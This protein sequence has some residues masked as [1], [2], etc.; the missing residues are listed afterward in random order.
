M[1]FIP[2]GLLLVTVHLSL[3]SGDEKPA[4]L[5]G[6]IP[7]KM[8]EFVDQHDIA[9]AVTV[10]GRKDSIL[11]F[12]AVGSL[13][14][15]KKQPM[16]KDALFRIA[17]MTKPITAIGIMMLVDEGKLSVDD[18]VEKHLP[19]FRGQMLIANRSAD[20]V[21]LK[22]P[23]RPI[24]VRDLLTHTSGLPGRWPEGLADLYLKRQRTLAEGV[25]A[26][27]QRPLEFEPG[28]KWAYCNPGIDTL[29]RI[30]EVLSGQPYE[31]FLQRRIFQP[32]GMTDTT[33]YPKAEQRDRIAATYDKKDGKLVRADHTVIGA[34]MGA[35]YP[36]P[37]GG[38]YSTGADL[39]KLYQMMLGRG[40]LGSTRILRPESVATMTSVQTGDLPTGFTPGMGFGFGWGVV[41]QPTGVTEMLSP[42]SYGHG[43]AFGT[44]GWIDPQ[45]DLF[46]ILLIQRVGLANSDASLIRRE[47]QALAV[48]ALRK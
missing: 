14:L 15:E 25:L 22:H 20:S 48:S 2:F 18:P 13:D 11:S 35:R 5:L 42:G 3:A 47:L 16:R 36:V 8:Q 39:A 40:A 4:G 32:L 45:Q 37:A 43:G 17:S 7:A 1:R 27:S 46:V 30:I 12:E 41:R 24:A 6:K 33:F 38:L 9:G 28:T 26:I 19:E 10:V 21:T 44:Q 29:G 31:D 23:S 34:P